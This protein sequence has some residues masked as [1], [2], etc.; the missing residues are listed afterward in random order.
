MTRTGKSFTFQFVSVSCNRSKRLWVSGK[1]Q[2]CNCLLRQL[3]TCLLKVEYVTIGGAVNLTASV[4][5]DVPRTSRGGCDVEIN[6]TTTTV[7]AVFAPFRVYRNLISVLRRLVGGAI[8]HFM[9]STGTGALFAIGGIYEATRAIMWSPHQE[10]P[11]RM[12]SN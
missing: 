10:T 2:Y 1:L 7:S 11:H 6:N 9:I 12:L 3:S 8:Q 4:Q 5:V